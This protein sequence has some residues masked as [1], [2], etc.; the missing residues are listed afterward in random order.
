M[1][2]I[3]ARNSLDVA[4]HFRCRHCL[5]IGLGYA[6]VSSLPSWSST[7][8]LCL[9]VSHSR[10]VLY[11]S[12]CMSQSIEGLFYALISEF[13]YL[14][15]FGWLLI[16]LLWLKLAVELVC[17][18]WTWRVKCFVG[19]LGLGNSF[20]DLHLCSDVLSNIFCKLFLWFVSIFNRLFPYNYTKNILGFSINCFD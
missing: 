11:D 9:F 10:S 12:G 19:E 13:A 14:C 1:R 2:K 17:C 4:G 16:A 15:M 3:V 8:I 20:N 7:F 6:S 5:V 18:I